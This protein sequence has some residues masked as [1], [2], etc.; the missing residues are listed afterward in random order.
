MKRIFL[1][2]LLTFA[3]SFFAF[4]QKVT[5]YSFVPTSS[6]FTALSGAT[7]ATIIGG[8]GM[9]EGYANAL[10]IGFTFYYIGQP[11]TTVS[12]STNGYVS[13]GGSMSAIN[14]YVNNLTTGA[15]P[16]SP[17]PILSPLWDDLNFYN[18][19]DISYQTTGASPNRIFTVQWLNARWD[20]TAASGISF[21][22]KLYEADSKIEF[23]Y[24]PE[25]GALANPSASIGIT[26]TGT[27][28]GNFLSITST[29]N[30]P[31]DTS[32]ITEYTTLGSKPSN[33]QKYSFVPKYVL[34]IA[35][36]SISY[37]SVGSTSI[38]LNWADNTTSETYYKIYYS[39]D[40]V[41]FTLLSTIYS[42]SVLTT[43]TAYQYP[44]TGLT[45]GT[46]YYFRVL[47][48]N[49]GSASTNYVSGSQS[50][51]SGFLSGVKSICPSG[52]YYTSIGAAATDIRNLGVNGSLILELDSSY[53]PTVET[54]P[55][56]FGILL[57]NASN[58]VTLRP[59]SNVNTTINF[60]S[61]VSPTFDFNGTGF[62]TIDGRK[63]GTGSTGFI[64]ISNFN[65][66]G[67]A[68]RFQN[69]AV[70]NTINYCRISGASSNS[71]SGVIN[72]LST[73][74]TLGNSNN[75]ISN[76]TIKDTI[77]NPIYAIYSSGNTNY[78]NINNAI[79]GNTI[80]D[81]FNGSN[82]T[83]G[84]YLTT[85]TDLWTI[86][87]NHFYQT[88]FRSLSYNNAGAV[89][90][91]SGSSYIVNGNYI[92][93]S[94][95]FCAG[96]AMNYNGTGSI[97]FIS[98]NLPTSNTC[99]IQNN[100]IRNLVL[101]LTGTPNSFINM[102]NG[103]FSITGNTIGNSSST[104]NIVFTS[105]ATNILFS[106]ILLTG[107]TSYG[108]ID[109]TS[110]AIGGI[111][112]GGAGTVQFRGIHVTT[113][114]PAL[115]IT[116]N[117]I[118]SLTTASSITDSTN[119]NLYGI[120]TTL[121]STS[122]LISGNIIANLSSLNTSTANQ[123]C[124]IF[125]SSTG[126]FSIVGNLIKNLSSTT[127]STAT[128]T[129]APIIGILLNA[130]GANQICSGN[131]VNGLFS[132]NTTLAMSL[133]GIHFQAGSTGSNIA[134]KNMVHGI[135]SL[136]AASSVINGIF[137]GSNGSSVY[138]NMIRVGLDT[139]G[140]DINANQIFTGINDAG[141]SNNYYFNSVYIGGSAVNAGA[142][143]SAAFFNST[144]SSGTRSVVN[145]VFY[146]ARS[147]SISSGKNYAILLTS[148]T[149]TGLSISY[150]IYYTPGVGGTL[151]RFNGVDYTILNNW[152]AAIFN[153]F[154]SAIGNPNFVSPSSSSSSLNLKVQSPTCAESAALFIA[155]ITD[156]YE[157]DIRSALTPSDI[158][159]D[160][161]NYSPVDIFSPVISYTNITNT[162]STTN[163]VL[164]ATIT[165][166]GLGVKNGG[167]L[168]PRIWY[169]R[170]LPTTSG[171]FSTPGTLA[172]GN[173]NN[174][175]WNFTIDYTLI[176]GSVITGNQYQYYIVAQDSAS[177]PNLF[178]NPL[179][180]AS[181][182]NVFNQVTTPTTP[183]QYSIVVGL[184]TAISVGTGQS[185]TNLTG[186]SGLFNAINTGALSANTIVTITSDISEPGT[187]ALNNT[188]MS[189][190]TLL[191]K[192]DANPRVLSGSTTTGFLGLISIFGASGV[193]IDGG[194]TKNLTIRNV[195]GTTPNSST[196]PA[197]YF[198][199]GNNDTLRNCIIES[200]A[201]STSYA[202]LILGTSSVS[203]SMA[204]MVIS[205]NIIRPPSN[206]NT[207]APAIGTMISSAA[208][209]IS[210]S[211]ISG[212]QFSDYS[213]YGIYVANAG[214]NLTIGHPTDTAQGN[215]FFQTTSRGNHYPIL[216]GSGNNHIISCNAIYNA[217]GVS[218]TGL[219][220]GVYVYNSINGITINNNSIGGTTKVRSGSPY[221]ISA[222]FYGVYFAGGSLATS[223]ISNNKIS[224]ISLS[225]AST[226]TGIGI[227]SGN[228]NITSNT[229]GGYALTT[230]S[231]DVIT[232]SQ[233]FYGIRHSTSAN[234][235]LSGNLISNISNTGSGFTTCMSIEGGVASI[236]GNTI[237]DITTSSTTNTA[238]DYSCNG[239]RIATTTSGNNIENNAIFNLTNNSS[240]NAVSVS[241]IAITTASNSSFIQRNRI[242]NLATGGAGTGV[243]SPIIWGVYVS[244]TG[245]NIF[246]NNQIVLN[247]NNAAV[248]PRIRGI[249]LNTSGGTNYFYYNS[250][251][252]G[253]LGGLANTSYSFFRNTTL[254][255]AGL[256]V[257]NNIFYNE[258]VSTGNHFAMGSVSVT[259][260]TN[261]NNLFVSTTT[262]PIEYPVGTSRTLAG[263]N[264]LAGNPV[265]N[266]SNTNAQLTS[267]LFFTNVNIADLSS[268][269][270]RISNA[271][272]VV[273]VTNDFLNGTRSVTTPD[274]GSTEFTIATGYPTIITQS[275]FTGGVCSTGGVVNASLSASGFNIVYQWMAN[276]GSGWSAI[277]NGAV[278]NGTNTANLSV[279]N[280]TISYN[281]YRYRCLVSGTCSPS[282]YSDS[283]TL[284]VTLPI[285]SNTISGVQT[286]CSGNT[287]SSLTGSLPTG[288]NGSTYVYQWISS[289]TN[290]TSG[291]AIASGTNNTQN[292]SS[293][294]LTQTTWF[295]RIVSSGVCGSDTTT[296]IQVTVNPL[297]SVNNLTGTQTI[298]S[299]STPSSLIGASPSGGTG[300]YTYI[301]Q[302]ST[303]SATAGFAIA[304]GTNN[305]QNYSPSSLTQTTWYR[306][307]VNSS[308]CAADTSTALQI[309][310][311]LPIT[312]NSISGIQTICA[313]NTPST[314]IG[315]IPGGGNG[316]FTYQ[317]LSTTGC[318]SCAAP[319]S[320]TN[321]T[322]NYSP[323]SLS[324]NMYYKRVITS[325][326]CATDTTSFLLVTV[327]PIPATPTPTSNSPVCNGSSLNFN[328][329][330][331][332]GATYAWTGPN[333]Y[334]SS[335]QSPSISTTSSVNTGTYSL[336]ITVT[337]CTS[338]AGTTSVAI[339]NPGTW[340]GAISSAWSN[341]A[342]WSCPQIPLSSTNVSIPSGVLNMPVITDAGRALNNLTI[343]AGA[344]LLLNNSAS[345]L[346]VYGS[347]INNGL[348][349][350]TAGEIIYTGTIN[351]TIA[352]GSYSKLTINNAAGTLLSGNVILSDSLKLTNG[353]VNIGKYLLTLSGTTGIVYN[354]SSSRY[355]ITSDTGYLVI[356]NIGSSGRSGSIL[357]PIGT[358][359]SYT[360]ITISNSTTLD[361]YYA[362]VADSIAESGYGN[363][364]RTSNVV[365]K[366][367]FAY[368]TLGNTATLS[369][370]WNL[371]D[372]LSGFNRSSS[373]VSQLLG[374]PWNSTVV[375]TTGPNPYV[376][377][378]TGVI[379]NYINGGSSTGL[380]GI[381]SGGALPVE[382]LSFTGKYNN[383]NA[384]LNWSTSSEINNNYFDIERSFDGKLFE[385]IGMQKGAGNSSS[386]ID[387]QFID[388]T[389]STINYQLSKVYY[390]LRQIDFDGSEQLTNVIN[391]R[392]DDALSTNSVSISPN[393]FTDIFSIT[394]K[395]NSELALTVYDVNGRMI[396]QSMHKNKVGSNTYYIDVLSEMKPGFYYLQII[397]DGETTTQKLVK[398]F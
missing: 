186:A 51:V 339:N 354:A 315:S 207:N 343:A 398:T 293:T 34:P 236:T 388:N 385:K 180:G 226:F 257:R 113:A 42:T 102:A 358:I 360:P 318:V 170:S 9:D 386:I 71:N 258:R 231:Y 18:T 369:L 311:T 127:S 218:H 26:G 227:G 301:W 65:G 134:S 149:L 276:T 288:G 286:I 202:T 45:L 118:G 201:G 191:I 64:N 234:L 28:A 204:G 246:A 397:I 230:N 296:A 263:W 165:D 85:G 221:L 22:L 299:G 313:G 323:S 44:V 43:G 89:F 353:N 264:V 244:A 68:I 187:I 352:A 307:V 74:G 33:G 396:N 48:G 5:N 289:T 125:A 304:S 330:T 58:V 145:N 63:G 336:T 151:G 203:N 40:T 46:L 306:R 248:Q 124:G 15:T 12:I 83:Y 78:P 114:V 6:S 90:A 54:Y 300:T 280:P 229:I 36:A 141:N 75:T 255:V 332:T 88:S 154:N 3:L 126:T 91:N 268:T 335:S 312:N 349:S 59:K 243:N 355:I 109:I 133:T 175:T 325:G 237:R 277:S 1:V 196:A 35:P 395:S 366:R 164:V 271:G 2:I 11:Y 356:Q 371:T 326:A 199:N 37:T 14:S 342:N 297:I 136:S 97:T 19:T 285:A 160:G 115:T 122:N 20:Y 317:W 144:A 233:D 153:D 328:T 183:N 333:S 7:S 384:Q 69:D 194:A 363:S 189:G 176:A 150:N 61:V 273:S 179:L 143:N 341:T 8:G 137:N 245:S 260:Y 77:S 72:F 275:T 94:A 139:L 87:N 391:I 60:I 142:N 283:I 251:Y 62:L 79:L 131:N 184:P 282:I 373:Y 225:G 329:T 217:T 96:S 238:A 259:N 172:L 220:I 210:N 105:S 262:S 292:Y 212:N 240:T 81:Y 177:T 55:L 192:P 334:S 162:S 213:S 364:Y 168:Q 16:L 182:T 223:T 272:A 123:L 38:T 146:N 4:S 348:F 242:Y 322:Q 169:R 156:D 266:L 119:L 302:S 350:S 253:G 73:T 132:S 17:R 316:S 152:R 166:I 222:G 25:A 185:Y 281:N 295:R 86:N 49:E 52:C 173:V 101:D 174:G 261:D 82:P 219:V 53:N 256:D 120:S 340:T 377:T 365:N 291:F 345:Q 320:G 284:S 67:T 111:S 99:A 104:N 394:T 346:S 84:V 241:G 23:I 370:Q 147:N 135:V 76:C 319:A 380:F 211:T 188:G 298:C 100:V 32:T 158:G 287:P 393:P 309:T 110:N 368:S 216:V 21:Q 344:S 337:G 128:G 56:N 190:Y 378:R 108:N 148:T 206:V 112:V 129:A 106:P 252:L 200:N 208:G 66:S 321:N 209:N 224:N 197:V 98:L 270:C 389:L 290:S 29:G 140:N 161:G 159:A 239:I 13:M 382:L 39:T 383:K 103:A 338:I 265:N 303:A 278:Y 181:H 138:N 294:S 250:V 92:G 167:L 254:A 10:S 193:T 361:Q 269:S 163:R 274:I 314:L 198:Y 279:T 357:F 31:Y 93:G 379:S 381:G 351:Q 390:R 308:S 116:G 215:T 121:T 375:A 232:T 359:T 30:N 387:Y 155:G 214:N 130:S 80:S 235:N 372:E 392:L 376:K 117:L 305:L 171:W 374:S 228:V 107:G 327:N 47:A 27:G 310:V 70:N 247:Q 95:P 205:N 362:R 267:T 331:V 24:R 249:E 367:W 178:Y 195:I 41:N 57:T 157:G 324:Q 50:T 347:V